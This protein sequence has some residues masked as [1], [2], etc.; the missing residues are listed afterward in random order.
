MLTSRLLGQIWA[1]GA[2]D[3]RITSHTLRTF[4]LPHLEDRQQVL[5]K[6]SGLIDHHDAVSI[7]NL[8]IELHSSVTQMQCGALELIHP[9]LPSLLR[10]Y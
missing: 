8:S 10:M 6:A 2:H 7:C 1:L 5:G 4:P 9:E 3:V